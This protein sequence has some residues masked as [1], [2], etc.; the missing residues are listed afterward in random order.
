LFVAKPDIRDWH[1]T[2]TEKFLLLQWNY[3]ETRPVH[4][5]FYFSSGNNDDKK[6]HPKQG[7]VDSSLQETLIHDNF[8]EG[9]KYY[10]DVFIIEGENTLSTKILELMTMFHSKSSTYLHKILIYLS[11]EKLLHYK[12]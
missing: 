6:V 3:T 11:I 4:M 1:S 8:H 12:L 7:Y 10:V 5:Q 9:I 2:L